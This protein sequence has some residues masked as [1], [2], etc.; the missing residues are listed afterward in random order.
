LGKPNDFDVELA[1]RKDELKDV[2]IYGAGGLLPLMQTAYCDPS[3]EHFTCNSWYFTI[4]DRK[5]CDNGRM[6]HSPIHFHQALD[7]ASRHIQ[8]LDVFVAQV[9]PM[10]QHGFFHFGCTNIYSLEGAITADLVILEVNEN[11]PRIPGGSEEAVH[12]SQIDYVIEGSNAPLFELPAAGAATE[13]DQAMAKILL[14]EIPDRACLQLGIGALPNTLGKL[15]CDSDLKDLGI[16]TEMFVDSMVELFDRGIVTN[17]YKQIDRGKIVFT[18]CIADK[19]TY[20]FCD[21]NPLL[22][23]HPCSY[24]NNPNVISRNSNLISINNIVEIDLFS[25]VCAESSGFRQISGTGGQVDFVHGA[26]MS[27]SGKSF[28]CLSSTFTDKE[29]N[30]HSRVVPTLQP[31]SIVTTPRT[32]VDYIVTEFG[33]AQLKGQS[34]WRRAELL[35]ELAHPQFRDELVK[36]AAK[37]GIWRL[38]NKIE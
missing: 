29:G 5:L 31:G 6:F 8:K 11:M 21:Q 12:V 19:A 24:T 18:F 2:F 38:T 4:V 7:M 36:E 26:W 35:I 27:P 20:D 10:D 28:L 9:S 23:S 30:L 17:K 15:L 14:E 37:M 22:A 34:S 3:H 13:A 25:Q 32:S 1:K 16:H 33:K